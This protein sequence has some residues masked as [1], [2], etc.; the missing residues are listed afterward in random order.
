MYFALS[1]APYAVF[2]LWAWAFRRDWHGSMA[3]FLTALP[4]VALGVW[5]WWPVFPQSSDEL[6]ADGKAI[7]D[8]IFMIEASSLQLLLSIV[9]LCWALTWSLTPADITRPHM[10][11]DSAG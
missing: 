5:A 1:F 8:G 2:A 7:A 6:I 11:A 9:A 4:A 3:V 10:A